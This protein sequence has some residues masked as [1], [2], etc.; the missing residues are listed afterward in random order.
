MKWYVDISYNYIS[1]SVFRIHTHYSATC[2]SYDIISWVLPCAL[3][4]QQDSMVLFKITSMISVSWLEVDSWVRMTRLI[5]AFQVKSLTCRPANLMQRM[6]GHACIVYY[7]MHHLITQ[8]AIKQPSIGVTYVSRKDPEKRNKA[9]RTA[10]PEACAPS[11]FFNSFLP[12]RVSTLGRWSFVGKITW[13]PESY[14]SVHRFTICMFMLQKDRLYLIST[15]L[16][17]PW[18]LV[19][20]LAS[21]DMASWAKVPNRRWSRHVQ[22]SQLAILHQFWYLPLPSPLFYAQLNFPAHLTSW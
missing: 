3:S 13:E 9:K 5:V 21:C 19:F 6:K 2:T 16:S 12:D 10:L 20:C 11:A 7:L 4:C 17:L 14:W 15:S 18:I 22:H 8:S 1:L